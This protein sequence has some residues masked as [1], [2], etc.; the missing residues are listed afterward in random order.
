MSA[1]ES[2]SCLDALIEPDQLAV[3]AQGRLRQLVS[4]LITDDACRLDPA[5]AQVTAEEARELA[6]E[7]LCCAEHAERLSSQRESE[8]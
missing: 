8:R 4:V 3:T 7:L 5:F 2:Y 6:F 1:Y